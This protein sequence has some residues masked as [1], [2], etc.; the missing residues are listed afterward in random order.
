MTPEGKRLQRA[1]RQSAALQASRKHL[2][3]ALRV[4]CQAEL[5][6]ERELIEARDAVHDAEARKREQV[7]A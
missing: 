5:E 6:A 1:V 4:L 2:E 3:H 7:P